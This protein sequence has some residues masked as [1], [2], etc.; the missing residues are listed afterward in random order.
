M[1]EFFIRHFGWTKPLIWLGAAL[2]CAASL[3][4]YA[5]VSHLLTDLFSHFVIYYLIAAAALMVIAFLIKAH[6]SCLVILA[7]VFALNAYTA[8]PYIP[9]RSAP[10]NAEKIFKIL[11]VNTL[12]LNKDTAAL[13]ALI[14]Q[15]NPDI[16]AASEVNGAFA[17]LFAGLRKDYPY[18]QIDARDTDARGLAILSRI[19]MLDIKR[20]F[21]GDG[22]IPSHTAIIRWHGRDI[23][24]ASIHPRT[25]LHGLRGRDA[26]FIALADKYRAARSNNESLIIT[27]DFN[28]TPW[29]PAQKAMTKALS[30]SNARAGFGLHSTWPVWL[31]APLRIPIDHVLIGGDIHVADYRTGPNI[32]SDHLPTIAVIAAP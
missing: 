11:Q 13:A 19:E 32:A 7:F 28:A 20:E 23:H 3:T 21:M 12:F 27:G 5:P 6:K 15:E 1:R 24:F 4:P 17:A 29:C 9:A 8:S 30:L 25:P 18:H 22:D 14:R 2:L 26:V 10:Q 31:P 16:I